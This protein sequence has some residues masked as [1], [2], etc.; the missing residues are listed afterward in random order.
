[1]QELNKS[2]L[3]TTLAAKHNLSPAQAKKAIGV[4][5]D[6]IIA[7]VENGERVE[8]RGMG[9]WF[10]KHYR[11][12][13]LRNPQN[14]EAVVKHDRVKIKFKSSIKIPANC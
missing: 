14:G 2:D 13:V 6:S 8:I 12:A 1:M 4:I 3:I 9:A 5:L 11:P 10:K 7:A